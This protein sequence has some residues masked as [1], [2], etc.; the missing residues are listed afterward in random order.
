MNALK[1]PSRWAVLFALARRPRP[2]P[3]VV[4]LLWIAALALALEVPPPDP[5]HKLV[6]D[7]TGTLT[8]QQVA[9]LN[10]KLREIERSDSTQIAVLLIPTLKGDD[11][12][13][14]AQRTFED[15]K[16]GIGQ[17]GKNNGVL[18]LVVKNDR[19]MRIQTGYGL[20]GRLTDAL[21]DQILRHEV[22]PAFY[23]GHF[24]QG[25]DR[26]TSA[27]VKAV[28]GEYKA[29]AP[30]GSSITAHPVLLGFLLIFFGIWGFI[31]MKWFITVSRAPRSRA[32][33]HGAGSFDSGGWYSGGGWPGM[34]GGGW[35]GGGS[36]GG[37]GGDI[38]FGGGRSG[39]GGASGSW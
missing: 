15:K 26:G 6:T 13:S 27:I 18:F 8:P 7:Y 38:G 29:S 14:F 37:G 30:G 16:W 10:Q 31:I 28:R 5:Q 33:G 22:K 25:I 11:L 1:A 19:K 3:V 2:L 39:G 23:E 20:E 9:Q 36:G 17:K 35:S 12:F 24:Y 32:M 21:S 34:G 4:L